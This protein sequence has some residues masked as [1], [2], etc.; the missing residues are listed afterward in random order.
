M[1]GGAGYIGSHA[2]GNLEAAGHSVV[3]F[4][5]LVLGHR[6]A[7]GSVPLVEG[8]LEQTALLAET[9]QLHR[10]DAVM[11]FAGRSRVSESVEHPDLYYRDNVAGTIS[12][13]EAMSATGVDRIVFSSSCATYGEP[14]SVPISEEALQRPVNPYGRTKLIIE[15]MLADHGRSYG[16]S[17]ASLRYFNACGASSDGELGEDH[18]DETH[19]IPLALQVALGERDCIQV[20]GDDYATPDGTCIRDYIHVD[21]LADAHTLALE[22]LGPGTE[23][24]LNLGT[25]R[26]YSVREVIDACRRVTDL[27]ILESVTSRRVGD[28][29]ALV[30]DPT[31]AE[32]LLGWKAQY[33]AIDDMVATAWTWHRRH[34]YGYGES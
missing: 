24:K 16:L 21:D 4:D 6:E 13:L 22:K 26:G 12:L 15:Q 20:F 19:L 2:V 28:P 3:V 32:R 34:P 8:F 18:E 29:P 31:L 9:M 14:G 23:M 11:H 27:P 25:G 7:V 5:S 30:A 33:T 10:V 17:Y 1:T